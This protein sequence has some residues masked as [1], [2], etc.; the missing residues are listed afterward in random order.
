[1]GGRKKGRTYR[2][3]KGGKKEKGRGGEGRG[4]EGREGKGR[5]GIKMSGLYREELLVEVKPIPWA[6]KFRVDS[7]HAL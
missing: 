3:K 6:G 4:G 5:E 1:V 7:S 2:E